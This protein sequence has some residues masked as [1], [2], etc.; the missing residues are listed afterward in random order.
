MFSGP[1]NVI[2]Y[3][4]SCVQ[5]TVLFIIAGSCSVMHTSNDRVF[6]KLF[7]FYLLPEILPDTCF[8]HI[9]ALMLDSTLQSPLTVASSPCSISKK[10]VTI[11]PL[12]QNPHQTVTR[13][14]YIG[15]SMYGCGFSVPQ[16]R[17]SCFFT[18]PPRSK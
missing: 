14:G 16:M 11:V 6:G 5:P 1:C 17:K 13:F 3:Y 10:N 2:Y 9:F 12:D 7:I 4:D 18:Y 8:F 15:F